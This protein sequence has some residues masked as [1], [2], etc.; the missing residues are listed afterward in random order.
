MARWFFYFVE[1]D[2][3]AYKHWKFKYEELKSILRIIKIFKKLN[4]IK[5]KIYSIIYGGDYAR[6]ES[7]KE[8]INSIRYILHI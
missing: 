1:R 3:K 5:I 2:E 4:K 8:K 6:D 7:K